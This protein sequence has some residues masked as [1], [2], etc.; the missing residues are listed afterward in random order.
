MY[1]PK[2]NEQ[3]IRV[4]YQLGKRLKKPMTHIVNEAIAEY[5]TEKVIKISPKTV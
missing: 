1:S 2:I 3:H 5:I 4:L